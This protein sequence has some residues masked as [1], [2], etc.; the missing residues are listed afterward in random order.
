VKLLRKA[1]PEPDLPLVLQRNERL[2]GLSYPENGQGVIYFD[3]FP[4]VAQQKPGSHLVF[5]L[6]CL[7]RP[8]QLLSQIEGEIGLTLLEMIFECERV[9]QS[10]RRIEAVTNND[11]YVRGRGSLLEAL[12][13]VI[14][15]IERRGDAVTLDDIPRKPCEQSY[16]QIV[17]SLFGHRHLW[18]EEGLYDFIIASLDA[19]YTKTD[20]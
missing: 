15:A 1:V 12:N 18:K 16:W 6:G 3:L 4:T 19:I 10:F 5:G 8:G 11:R 20:G 13:N 9:R 2:F 14:R 17:E 7:H